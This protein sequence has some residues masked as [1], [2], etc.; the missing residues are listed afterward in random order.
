MRLKNKNLKK[1]L[2]FLK[3]CAIISLLCR[4]HAGVMELAD[5]LDSKSSGSDTVR[6]RP[7]PPAPNSKN[8]NLIKWWWGSDLSLLT[9]QKTEGFFS[10]LFFSILL[11]GN[12]RIGKV[13]VFDFSF[14]DRVN[15]FYFKEINRLHKWW[16]SWQSTSTWKL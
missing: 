1:H 16:V 6:V 7:P 10:P 3:Y 2:I 4:K 12:K 11:Y 13:A 15:T 9:V 8:P 14:V 5:V